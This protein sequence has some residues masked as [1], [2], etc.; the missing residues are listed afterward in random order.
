MRNIHIIYIPH[1]PTSPVIHQLIFHPNKFWNVDIY[2]YEIWVTVVLYII[3]H[4]YFLSGW[5]YFVKVVE[6]T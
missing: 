5:Y 6:L 2:E 1:L 4:V 3:S